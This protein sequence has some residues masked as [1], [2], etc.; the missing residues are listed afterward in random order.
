MIENAHEIIEIVL[1]SIS[2]LQLGQSVAAHQNRLFLTKIV[3]N[4]SSD[5]IRYVSNN[6][7]EAGSTD[8]DITSYSI[9]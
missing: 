1:R 2:D 9:H 8:G 6:I 3:H 7:D 5:S 4:S